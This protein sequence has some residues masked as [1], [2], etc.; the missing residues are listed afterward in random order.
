MNVKVANQIDIPIRDENKSS[1]RR[2]VDRRG[3]VEGF[4]RRSSKTECLGGVFE[5]FRS[6]FAVHGVGG[7][8]KP[9]GDSVTVYTWYPIGEPGPSGMPRAYQIMKKMN[10]PTSMDTAYG[11]DSDIRVPT[12]AFL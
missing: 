2:F 10:Q 7:P 5:V 12:P 6:K 9:A 8:K 4:E 11:S 3:R 1:N